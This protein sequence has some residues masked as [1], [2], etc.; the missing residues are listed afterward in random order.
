[1]THEYNNKKTPSLSEAYYDMAI[2]REGGGRALRGMSD[3]LDHISLHHVNQVVVTQGDLQLG[4]STP[5]PL[6]S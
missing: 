1:M 5:P 4:K 2:V 3:M 6:Q